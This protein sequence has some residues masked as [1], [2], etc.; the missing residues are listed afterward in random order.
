MIE[1]LISKIGLDKIAHFGIGAAICAFVTLVF[2]FSLPI[3]NTQEYSWSLVLISPIAGYV[4]TAIMAWAKEM[5]DQ[6]PDIKDFIA[7]MLGCV[8]IHLGVVIGW[9]IHF[10]NGKDLITTWWG[11]VIFGLIMATLLFFWV[12]WTVRFFKKK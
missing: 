9:L 7:S 6:S 1:R 5:N 12:R 11:W 10:G 4:L 3:G 8:F 2:V